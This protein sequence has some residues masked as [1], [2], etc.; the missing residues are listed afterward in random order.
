MP[1]KSGTT[2]DV[3]R[4]KNLQDIRFDSPNIYKAGNHPKINWQSQ[5]LAKPCGVIQCQVDFDSQAQRDVGHTPSFHV[6]LGRV[7]KRQ[8]CQRQ[9]P[10]K[11]SVHGQGSCSSQDKQG[12][13]MT[14]LR[15]SIFDHEKR[16]DT[17][18]PETYGV[19]GRA[20]K[21]G[22]R[23]VSTCGAKIEGSKLWKTHGHWFQKTSA[24]S[25]FGR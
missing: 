1:L 24:C 6:C 4:R 2:L 12:H 18:P 10:L 3:S 25:W 5:R 8:R 16:T 11:C 23:C 9:G 20:S 17:W 22:R 13:V 14:E 19:L 15:V 21:S 7:L